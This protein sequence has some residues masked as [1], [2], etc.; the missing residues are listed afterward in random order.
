MA[1]SAARAVKNL[2]ITDNY[3]YLGSH[4]AVDIRANFF[5][6]NMTS[7]HEKEAVD[8]MMDLFDQEKNTDRMLANEHI[9]TLL[10]SVKNLMD[11]FN[12]TFDQ[13]TTALKL[14][15]SDKE[16]LKIRL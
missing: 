7:S 8:I 12:L 14:S 9:E 5:T 1:E 11:N 3:Q 15:G 2:I 13:A 6:K 4:T 10:E 16:N